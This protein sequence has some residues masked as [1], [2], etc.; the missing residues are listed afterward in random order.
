MSH[1]FDLLKNAPFNRD[2]IQGFPKRT[3]QGHICG[4]L[5]TCV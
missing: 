2:S 4:H 1:G 5:I 3:E